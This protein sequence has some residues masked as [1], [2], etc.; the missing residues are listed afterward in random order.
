[1]GLRRT[2]KTNLPRDTILH[3]T[4]R[5]S[6]GQTGELKLTLGRGSDD[7]CWDFQFH[8]GNTER[9]KTSAGYFSKANR[10]HRQARLENPEP[11][12]ALLEPKPV[13]QDF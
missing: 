11:P 3:L 6:P 2:Q 1:M 12:K 7:F 8:H 9:T 5:V 10:P 4:H 13:P